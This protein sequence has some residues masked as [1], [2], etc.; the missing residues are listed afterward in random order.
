MPRPLSFFVCAVA[1]VF[2]A[3]DSAHACW[4]RARCRPAPVCRPGPSGPVIHPTVIGATYPLA[5]SPWGWG[6]HIA[7]G[8]TDEGR[9]V[10]GTVYHPTNPGYGTHTRT[11]GPP[12]PQGHWYL[13]FGYLPPANGLT[14]SLT[15]G[16]PASAQ[17]IT[18]LK[19]P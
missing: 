13:N 10:T 1:V 9:A 14:L 18:G 15:N 16:N 5:G 12:T 3:S 6:P 4:R 7:R 8:Q 11:S 2:V 17:T 19:I